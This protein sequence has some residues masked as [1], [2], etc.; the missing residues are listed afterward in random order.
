M[1]ETTNKY[2]FPV[3]FSK[4]KLAWHPCATMYLLFS[5]LTT[6]YF[7]LPTKLIKICQHPKYWPEKC[8]IYVSAACDACDIYN[9][10]T[11]Q[12]FYPG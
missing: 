1:H 2:K 9:V 12:T 6:I 11:Q 7:N 10:W 5:K 4:G 8:N 3:H